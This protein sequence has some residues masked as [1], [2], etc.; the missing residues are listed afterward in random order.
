M[1][2]RCSKCGRGPVKGASRSHSNIKTKRRVFPN[3]QWQ[4]VG[5]KRVKICTRCLRTLAKV[6]K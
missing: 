6:R 3:L 2:R 4:T 5:G 1:S